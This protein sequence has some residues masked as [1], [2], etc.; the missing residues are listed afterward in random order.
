MP[1][2]QRDSTTPP[3]IVKPTRKSLGDML[4][5][6][7]TIAPADLYAVT[8]LVRDVLHQAERRHKRYFPDKAE[9]D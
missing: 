5:R 6:L 8:E 7:A 4:Q 1:K 2:P 9:G 3:H